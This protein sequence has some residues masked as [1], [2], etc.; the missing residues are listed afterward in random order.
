ML[1]L[2]I[3]NRN[4]FGLQALLHFGWC[5][6]VVPAGKQSLPVYHPVGWYIG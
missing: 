6:V 1:H 3:F 5:R 2:I 4:A